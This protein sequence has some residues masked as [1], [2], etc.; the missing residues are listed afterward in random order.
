MI[1]LSLVTCG[2]YSFYWYYALGNRLQANANEQYTLNVTETG[3]TILLWM[4]VGSL[5]CGIGSF[6][7]T[8]IVIKNTNALA[9]EYNEKLDAEEAYTPAPE[10]EEAPAP[11][12][13]TPEE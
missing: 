5:I 1:L 11:E 9:R 13:E 3:T 12:A 6:V 4:V 10:A 7:A 2:I 8:H